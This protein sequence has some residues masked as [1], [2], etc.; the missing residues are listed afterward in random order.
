MSLM[1]FL[2]AF[3][4]LVLQKRKIQVL[5]PHADRATAHEIRP[6]NLQSSLSDELATE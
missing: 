1:A 5:L 4:Q 3:R 6:P 2:K